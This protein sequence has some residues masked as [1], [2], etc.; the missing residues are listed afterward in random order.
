MQGSGLILDIC[1]CKFVDMLKPD[2]P[3]KEMKVRLMQEI[4]QEHG[5]EW[6]PNSLDNRLYKPYSSQHDWSA[7]VDDHQDKEPRITNHE[8]GWMINIQ[9]TI[10]NGS[11]ARKTD[12]SNDDIVKQTRQ[13]IMDYWSRTTS[14]FS[15]SQETRSSPD[16]S[17]TSSD[18]STKSRPFFNFGLMPDK[19][20]TKSDTVFYSPTNN[21]DKENEDVSN[22]PNVEKCDDEK[23]VAAPRTVKNRWWRKGGTLPRVRLHPTERLPN[24][25]EVEEPNGIVSGG[26][27]VN[28]PTG[29]VHPKLPDYDEIKARFAALRSKS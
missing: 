9:E 28:S 14:L 18:D 21:V 27:Y 13:R 3:T 16:E 12:E 17:S 24:P 11:N 8:N 26:S 20:G 7:N 22:H 23:V 1:S 2:R 10:N 5:V 29:H 6:D 25:V 19:T 15:T 4:A